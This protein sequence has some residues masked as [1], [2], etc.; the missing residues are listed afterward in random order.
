[1]SGTVSVS[2][3]ALASIAAPSG[4]DAVFV[5]KRNGQAL[6]GWTRRPSPPDVVS[7]MTATL[8]GSSETLLETLGKG[9]PAELL[10]TADST[11]FLV[12]RAGGG[13]LV[14]V[15]GPASVPDA[16][17]RT[18]AAKVAALLV[19]PAVPARA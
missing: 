1:M 7:V 18:A 15:V 5:L 13:S 8:F 4:L 6:S 3:E 11:R 17:L 9:S 16:Q 2:S 14:L 19:R 10:V 12:R